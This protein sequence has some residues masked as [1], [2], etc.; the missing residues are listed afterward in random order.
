MRFR[1]DH[2]GRNGGFTLAEVLIAIVVCVIF[3]VAAYATNERLLLSLKAQREATAASMMLQ[4]R[5]E[6]FRARAYSEVANKDFVKNNILTFNPSPSPSPTP[7]FP[8][9]HG[10][11]QAK[12]ATWSE[13]SLNNLQETV[14]VSGYQV[15][16]APNPTPS[17]T[18]ADNYNQW[19][20]D[21]SSS[22]DGTPHEQ[23]HDDNLANQFDLVKVD[24]S[25]TWTGANGRSRT[26]DLSAIFGKGNIGP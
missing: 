9:T 8:P 19:T 26:R 10:K 3:A 4:E 23:N 11:S 2:T 13:G 20:R 5:M 24:I 6:K 12:Y 21:T 18:P 25:I 7:A 1:S 16:V 17:A 22:G 14:T 15:A